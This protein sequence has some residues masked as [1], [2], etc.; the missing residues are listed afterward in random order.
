MVKIKNFYFGEGWEHMHK[1]SQNLAEERSNK[2]MKQIPMGNKGLEEEKKTKGCW[3]SNGYQ[4]SDLV[5][6]LVPYFV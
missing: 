1:S 4:L 2:D 3:S 5:M 6:Y